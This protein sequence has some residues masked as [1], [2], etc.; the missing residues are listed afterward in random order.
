M[1]SY[2]LV[3]C[4]RICVARD[5]RDPWRNGSRGGAGLA[6][7]QRMLAVNVGGIVSNY[8][9]IGHPSVQK[10]LTLELIT[11]RSGLL[12]PLVT[13]SSVISFYP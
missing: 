11:P 13:T 4:R 12:P 8:C 2:T 1:K 5:K 3:A 6:L 10:L 7:T 9:P